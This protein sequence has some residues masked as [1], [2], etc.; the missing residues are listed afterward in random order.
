MTDNVSTEKRLQRALSQLIDQHTAD[1]T[2]GTLT[3]TALCQLAGVSRTTLYRYHPACCS[4]STSAS[5]NTSAK[6]DR[7]HSP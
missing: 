4:R 6:Q 1:R 5:A 7:I 3:A 2:P